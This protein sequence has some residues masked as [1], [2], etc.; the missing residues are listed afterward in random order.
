MRLAG[1][2]F[3]LDTNIL[4]HLLRGDATGQE[5]ERTY[6]VGQRTPR[7]VLIE[8]TTIRDSALV[9]VRHHFMRAPGERLE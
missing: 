4:V 7:D 2:Q 1:E 5:L 3:V 8:P 9:G 6:K